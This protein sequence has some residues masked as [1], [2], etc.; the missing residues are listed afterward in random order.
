MRHTVSLRRRGRWVSFAPF[1]TAF[2]L[3]RM[4]VVRRSELAG[5][6]KTLATVRDWL[7]E[8]DYAGGGTS[9]SRLSRESRPSTPP[10]A[11]GNE[12]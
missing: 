1:D 7:M 3:L 2:C 6:N 8:N 5:L 12:V 10:V 11:M 4:L 9:P